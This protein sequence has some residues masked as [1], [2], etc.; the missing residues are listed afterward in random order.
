VTTDRGSA[1][2]ST[3]GGMAVLLTVTTVLV[4]SGAA[5]KTRHHA[6]S[7]A[8]LAALAAAGAAITGETTACGLAKW[9]TDRMSVTLRSCTVNG[10]D[11]RVEVTAR[12]PGVLAGFGSTHARSRAGPV[13]EVNYPSRAVVSAR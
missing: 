9:V 4:W 5:I 2:V 12:P 11:A 3:V 1:S 7:A 8:D 6:Q 13:E 10:W